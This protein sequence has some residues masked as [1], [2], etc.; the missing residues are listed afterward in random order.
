MRFRRDDTGLI[1][2]SRPKITGEG[3]KPKK[4]IKV[5]KEKEEE[6][7]GPWWPAFEFDGR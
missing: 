1:K 3:E 4:K 7:S 5:E 6:E 2:A